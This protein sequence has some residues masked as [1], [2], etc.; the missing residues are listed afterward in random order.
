MTNLPPR[1]PENASE[2]YRQLIIRIRKSVK[3]KE[4]VVFDPET[5]IMK[6]FLDGKLLWVKHPTKSGVKFDKDKE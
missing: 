6:C 5:G 1:S 2:I 3:D 4:S